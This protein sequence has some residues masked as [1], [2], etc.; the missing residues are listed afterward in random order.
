M[1]IVTG[2]SPVTILRMFF[3]TL[4]QNREIYSAASASRW[5]RCAKPGTAAV[6][7]LAQ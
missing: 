6:A 7:N 3:G 4:P 1:V 5:S 2:A